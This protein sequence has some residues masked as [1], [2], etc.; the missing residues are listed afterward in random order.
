MS[1]LDKLHN[2]KDKDLGLFRKL[3]NCLLLIH[4]FVDYVDF[5]FWCFLL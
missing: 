2:L 5:G 4:I 1:Y 3:C